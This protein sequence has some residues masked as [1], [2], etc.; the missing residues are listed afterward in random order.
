MNTQFWH[1]IISATDVCNLSC[2]PNCTASLS[3]EVDPHAWLWTSIL[4]LPL[5]DSQNGS[6]GPASIT[7]TQFMS[8][9]SE[10]IAIQLRFTTD[11]NKWMIEIYTRTE[12][13]FVSVTKYEST[14][15]S[16]S[17]ASRLLLTW[18]LL[19]A[20][21]EVRDIFTSIQYS[22]VIVSSDRIFSH[23]FPNG[24]KF[25]FL[26]LTLKLTTIF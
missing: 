6:L 2:L 23:I 1:L 21:I 8:I 11:V 25:F 4:P 26:K 20:F 7:L 24:N 22:E 14:I 18:N 5:P 19:S 3:H 15:H 13:Q 10:F 12:R 16:T 9:L 17:I